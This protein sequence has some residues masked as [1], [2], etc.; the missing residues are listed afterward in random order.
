VGAKYLLSAGRNIAD[1][2]HCEMHFLFDAM[3]AGCKFVMIDPRFTRSA[4]KADDWLPVRPGADVALALGMVN[5]VVDA[6]LVKEDYVLAHTNG[7]F[8]ARRDTQQ[9]LRERDVIPGGGDAYMVWDDAR[10][11]PTPVAVAERPL[12]RGAWTV[13]GATGARIECWTGF[14]ASWAEWRK[15][16][17]DYASAI[18]D[19][20]AEQI[21]RTALDY[22]TTDPAWLW[23]G[24]GPQRYHHGHLVTRAW[25]T[26]ATLCGNIGKRYAG[27]SYCDGP[28]FSMLMNPWRQ[29]ASPKGARRGRS[30]NGTILVD[31]IATGAPYEIRSLWMSASGFAT[32][33]PLFR[34]FVEEALPKLDLF[35]VTEQVMTAAAEQ[36]D[37]VLPCT[38]YYEEDWDLIGGGEIWF[39]QLRRQAVA[40]VGESR[41]DYDIFKG[42]CERMGLGVYWQTDPEEE[43]R[44]ILANSPDPRI[45]AVDWEALKRDGVARVPLERPHTPFADMTFKTPSGRIELYQEQFADQGEAVVLHREPLESHR[46]PHAK[47]YPLVL[48]SYKHTHSTHGQ[49]SFLPYMRELLPHP[50]VEI[51]PDDAAARGIEEGDTVSVFNERAEFKVKAQVSEAVRPGTLAI[52][53]GWWPR[54]FGGQHPAFLGHLPRNAVQERLGETNTP[55]WDVLCEVRK[56]APSEGAAP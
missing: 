26:L 5:V 47:R 23:M 50:F 22:A 18:C 19:V 10:G 6:G 40:P 7:A 16:T 52:K 27:M 20:P 33:T 43:C 1:T 29:L 3:E 34:R 30:L 49:H 44:L 8:L 56:A 54:D 24:Y 21:R 48:I 46:A 31:A 39:M 9:L 51:S 45:R 35:V 37:I 17:P 32:Q 25:A 4:A 15:Y 11:A 14:E 13:A 42:L 2:A 55:H 12:L 28:L 53:Q 36:A 41:S 38:S